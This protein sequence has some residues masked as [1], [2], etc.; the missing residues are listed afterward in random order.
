M[1]YII[2]IPD[3]LETTAGSGSVVTTG[4]GVATGGAEAQLI[5]VAIKQVKT[6]KDKIVLRSILIILIFC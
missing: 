4:S 1:G 3:D 6:V 5:E 2:P